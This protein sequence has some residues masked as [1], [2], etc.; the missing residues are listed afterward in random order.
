[1][2]HVS[3]AHKGASDRYSVQVGQVSRA[4]VRPG[5]RY[6]SPARRVERV[7]ADGWRTSARGPSRHASH[8]RLVSNRRVQN[9]VFS[10]APRVGPTR[11]SRGCKPI[12]EGVARVDSTRGARGSRA[13][14]GNYTPSRCR[15]PAPHVVAH[16][17]VSRSCL[18][19]GAE[20]VPDELRPPPAA[21]APEPP[22]LPVTH[23]AAAPSHLT[24]ILGTMHASKGAKRTA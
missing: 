12:C 6:F 14:F 1:M 23:A 7:D 16:I 5:D 4:H 13:N 19:V 9:S 17:T 20:A 21:S 2:R 11:A 18:D 3:Q 10:P 8:A 24:Y 15:P 22:S